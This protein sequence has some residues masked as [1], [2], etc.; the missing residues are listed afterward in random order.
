MNN[1]IADRVKR[2]VVDH[3]GVSADSVTDIT[4]YDE[5][6]ADSLDTVELLMAYEEEFK[7]EITDEQAI[8]VKTIGDAIQL[9]TKLKE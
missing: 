7:L 3:L 8:N 9:I 2:I 5:L 1:D 6:G 4:T